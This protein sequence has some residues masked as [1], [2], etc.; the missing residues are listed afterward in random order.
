[1]Y[2]LITSYVYV[3]IYNKIQLQFMDYYAII[4]IICNKSLNI[5][6][7]KTYISDKSHNRSRLNSSI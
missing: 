3:V 5:N 2:I 1:M 7:N 4:Y 6:I